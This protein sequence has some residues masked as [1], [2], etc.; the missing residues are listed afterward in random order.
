MT[1]NFIF[2]IITADETW[3]YGY[4]PETTQQLSQ[5]NSPNSL[6]PKKIVSSLQQCQVHVDRFYRHP[7]HCPQ[8]IRTPW[9]N[10]Q[11]QVLLWGFE[12][13][14]GGHSAQMS[15]QVGEN[16]W[17]LHHDNTPA[18]T[19]LFVWQFLTSKNITV[20]PPPIH[21]FLPLR[22]FPISPRW[23]YGRKG[24]I[25]T[26]L[27]RS[28]QKCKR[29]SRHSHMRTSRDAW[30]H[31]KHAGIAVYMLKWTTLKETVETRSYGKKHFFL[32]SNTPNFWVA[33]RTSNT[34][35][36]TNGICYRCCSLHKF[37]LCYS[38]YRNTMY[39]WAKH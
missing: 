18:H 9:S 15:R 7:K 8:V 10:H 37:V 28:M 34:R 3:A 39:F 16:N 35:S 20:I 1:P 19:S 36:H 24:V 22:L 26:R 4:D 12:V 6:W 13:D 14:E 23:N 33:P 21:L 32:W 29:L 25:L 38:P 27:R 30:N 11:W 2:N 5:W 17:F 31:G